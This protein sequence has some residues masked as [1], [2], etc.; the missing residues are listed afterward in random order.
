MKGAILLLATLPILGATSIQPTQAISI[1]LDM[2]KTDVPIVPQFN[3]DSLLRNTST[4]QPYPPTTLVKDSILTKEATPIN[5]PSL[6]M[7]QSITEAGDGTGTT[8]EQNGNQ[9]N[10]DGG[11]VS[12]DGENLFHSFQDFGLS[13]GEIANFLSNPQIRNILGRVVGGEASIINGLIQ[14]TGGNSNLFLM[15][16]AGIVFGANARLNVPASFTATT[17]TGIGFEGDQWFNVFSE[18]NYQT[19]IGDPNQ[20]AFDLAQPA[21]LI[22]GGNLAVSEGHHLTLLAGNTINTGQL[23]APGGTITMAAVPESNRV[24]ISQPGQLLSLEIVPSTNENGEIE[25]I[26]PLDLPTLLTGTEDSVETGLTVTQ[27]G[28]VQ[29]QESGL[30]VPAEAGVAIASGTL[31]VSHESPGVDSQSV[32]VFGN[33]VGVFDAT[34]NASGMYGG[35]TVRLGGDYQGQ[36]TFN[37]SQTLVSE[38][39]L[40]T[41]D[42]GEQGTGGEVFIWADGVTGFYGTISAR[43]GTEAGDG[44]FIEVSGKELLIFTGHADAGALNGQPGTLLLDPKNITIGDANSPLAIRFN[45]DNPSTENQFGYSVATLGSDVIVGDPR[46]D[47]TETAIQKTDVGI[48]YL[49]DGSTGEKLVTFRTPPDFI[50]EENPD[51]GRFGFAVAGMGSDNVIIGA[52]GENDENGRVYLFDSKGIYQKAFDNPNSSTAEGDPQLGLGF[53]YSVAAVGSNVLVGSPGDDTQGT[54][55]GAAYLFDGNTGNQLHEFF[56]PNPTGSPTNNGRFGYSVA[57]VDSNVLVGAPGDNIGVEGN[58][59]TGGAAYLFNSNSGDLIET[60]TSPNATD[61][62]EFGISVAAM[63]SQILVGAPGDNLGQGVQGAAY[64]FNQDGELQ[65]T[66]SSPNADNG[67]F[68]T[69]VAAVES[70]ESALGFNVV[71]SA[72]GE[73]ATYLYEPLPDSDTGLLWQ[74]F[75]K[76]SDS[77]SNFGNAVAGVERNVVVGAPGGMNNAGDIY[78]F[79]SSFEFGDNPDQSVTIDVETITNITNTGTEIEFQANNDITVDA[80]ILTDNPNG[81]GGALSLRAGRGIFVNADI[82]TDD[83]NLSFI[84]NDSDAIQAFRDPGDAFIEIASDARLNSGSGDIYLQ[85]DPGEERGDINVLGEIITQTGDLIVEHNNPTG[86]NVKI[87]NTINVGGDVDMNT[88]GGNILASGNVETTNG[89]ISFASQGGNIE[90]QNGGNVFANGGEISFASQ[91]G[92]IEI[93]NGGNVS[94]NGDEIRFNSQ[95]GTIQVDTAFTL[96][97]ETFL[98]TGAGTGDI[99]FNNLLDGTQNLNL[100]AGTGNVIFEG[101]VGSGTPLGNLTIASAGNVTAK[102]A[103]AASSFTHQSGTGTINLANLRDI[104]ILDGDFSL[105][106]TNTLTVGNITAT[107]GKVELSANSNLTTEN[108]TT[109]GDTINLTS[110][111]GEVTSGNLDSG[112][113]NVGVSANSNLNTEDITTSGGTINLTSTQG[114]VNSGNLNSG[115]GNVDATASNDLNTANITTSGGTINL[116]STQGEV[117]S[118][119]LNSAGG[120]VDASASNDLNTANITTSG[121]T[122]NLTSKDEK[123]NTGDLN[124]SAAIG[125][126]ITVNAR[127]SITTEAIN[128]SGTEGDGG[129]V[130]LDPLE[131]I[132]VNSIN[133]Q[134]GSNGQGG[135]VDITTQQFFQATGSF[136]DQNGIEASISTAGGNGGGDITIRHGGGAQEV[137]KPFIVGNGSENGTAEAITSG[138]FTIAP[139]QSFPGSHTLG[140]IRIITTD[141]TSDPSDPTDPLIEFK[142]PLERP[143]TPNALDQ[144]PIINADVYKIERYFTQAFEK[145]MGM[146]AEK[147]LTLDEIRN[148]L[149]SIEVATGVKPAVIYGVF[150]PSSTNSEKELELMLVTADRDVI[151][152]RVSGAKQSDVL[153]TGQNFR[154]EILDGGFGYLDDAKQLY[155]WMVAPLETDLQETGIENLVF[156]LDEGLRSLPIAAIHDGDNFIVRRYSVSLMP[157]VSLTDTRYANIKTMPVLAMGASDF[158]DNPL[159]EKL[160]AAAA[161]VSILTNT[162]WRGQA[163]LNENFTVNNL[164]AKREEKPFGIIHL[165]THAEFEP[166]APS[167]SYIQLWDTQVG[168]D[169]VRSLGWHDPAVELV[170]LSACRTALGDPSAELGFAGFAAKAGVKS[171]LASLWYIEDWGTLP[172]M[173][174]FYNNLDDAPI[175]AEA[176][177]R[178]QMAMIEGK[179]KY[180]NNQLILSDKAIALPSPDAKPGNPDLSHPYYWSAFSIVGN[181]W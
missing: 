51:D 120:N 59:I 171:V 152:K 153:N 170:V 80:A 156:I 9:F 85:L 138:E 121:G 67:Q 172:M 83:G 89:E 165:A 162:L 166:G 33:K 1:R 93:Q 112:G 45:P 76:P 143:P 110:Q 91:G 167:N 169:E 63:G 23:T 105:N 174:E 142:R 13:A 54:D 21:T 161:E 147:I 18:N 106:T 139:V 5:P 104:Q 8:V 117:N 141:Q 177:R 7:A 52:P 94:T 114:E 109:S 32:N 41:A 71:V 2:D 100:T 133:A 22:N 62:G 72:P 145:Q 28:Q 47:E 60:F 154:Q 163:F 70:A 37:A 86:G 58:I 140:N 115:G 178:A 132:T 6:I 124:S 49:F 134:G 25:A 98:S 151:T 53:G 39:S 81:T 175:K 79:G 168:I 44:G 82:T 97:G 30:S 181:P 65:N 11:T 55:T 50:D 135:D 107:D 69:S 35:G 159:L 46:Y 77:P 180:E 122:I 87:E 149:R 144:E 125:G 73:N 88:T 130:T 3:P 157:S 136:T 16:P 137:I 116:T 84:A 61:T 56:S 96:T 111:G 19:L 64:W 78:L 119:N 92:N 146:E 155:Q 126:D 103:I 118:G 179:V 129:N 15:N 43:G 164:K 123:I 12:G 176:W 74:T 68:G 31:D 99:L 27:T 148:R 29:L 38:N 66:F 102:D 4:T 101:K 26:D 42:A 131:D 40:I 17:A 24:R 34:I 113:G 14:V 57:G 173:A 127:I 95:G 160:P 36:G 128:S 10:I 158:P 75:L 150:V 20:F 90:I 108:I 48:A